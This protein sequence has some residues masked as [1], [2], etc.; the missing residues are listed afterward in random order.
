MNRVLFFLLFF[1][2]QS[3]AVDELPPG[4]L[5]SE[6][7]QFKQA[8][9]QAPDGNDGPLA[10]APIEYLRPSVTLDDE[11]SELERVVSETL[12]PP[13]LEEQMQEGISQRKLEQYGYDIFSGL[14]STFAPVAAIPVPEDYI[15]GPGDT[16]VVQVFG[17]VDV[18]YNLVVTREGRVLV[19]ELGDIQVAGLRFDEAK[20]LIVESLERVRIGAK[21]IATLSDL[22]TVQVLLVGEVSQP[23]AYTVSGLSSLLNTLVS[24]G[25]IRRTGSLRNIQ[26]KRSGVL[27]ASFDLY[28][29]LLNGDESNNIH[30]RHGDVVFVPPIGATIGV[31]GEVQRAAIY[32]LNGE[33]TVGD[34]LKLAG[35]LLP[36]AAATK[37]QIERI[38]NDDFYTLIEADLKGD[39]IHTTLK[40]GDLI[41]VLPVIEK[42]SNV[43][44]LDG[45][46]IAP[47]SYQ[48]RDGLKIGS[49]IASR[50]ML[51]QGTDFGITV[52]EREN[53]QT[54]R[55][56]VIYVDLAAA[57]AGD[58][59]AN[60][61]LQP[62]DRI[63]V[64]STHGNRSGQLR[65]TVEKLEREATVDQ[66]APV[67]YLNGFF[68]HPG[69]YPLQ[70]GLRVTDIAR[71]AGGIKPGTD[72]NYAVLS[73]SANGDNKT[74]ITVINLRRSIRDPRGDHNPILRPSDRLYFFDAYQDRPDLLRPEIEKLQKQAAKNE[75]NK[76]I[77]ISGEIAHPG[78][79]PL[80]AGMRLSDLIVAG[81]GLTE[82]ASSKNAI[83]ARRQQQADE[84]TR[85]VQLEVDLSDD[86]SALLA[87]STVLRPGDE[88]IIKSKPEWV[89]TTNKVTIKGE[90]LHPGTYSVDKRETLCSLVQRAGGFT[91]NAYLFG[92]VFTRE[93]VRQREQQALDRVMGELDDLLAEVHLSP[94]YDK[95]R[96]L[97][98]DR[99]TLDTYKVIKDLAPKKAVGR[100]VID[101]EGAVKS[102]R[103]AD[104]IV[105]ENGDTIS[106]PKYQDEVSVVGQVYFPTSHKF[107]SERAALDYINLSGGT[108]ELAQREHAYVVQANGEVM[109]VRSQA[110]TWGWLMSPSN[111]RVT[112]GST[113][114]VPLSVDRINGREFAQSWVDL[115]YKLTLGVASV[116]YLF[117]D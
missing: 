115:F 71:F 92:T 74:D 88:L 5:N 107:K 70:A 19:P 45:H 22:R 39:G 99:N 62:R 86:N 31:A 26:V 77:S 37:T 51:R 85:V 81:G 8:R 57:L 25:G 6:F 20:E 109:T 38:E 41:R 2:T 36:T 15:I 108:K 58:P 84:F 16:F 53:L 46:V 7:L 29:L 72:L 113:V 75:V 110:S 101:M 79:Y 63:V 105:L 76:T 95:D 47:G 64:F 49:I 91:E 56:E 48:W 114:F 55:S 106:I 11:P 93:S 89:D 14:A 103:E 44:Y 52:I 94:G 96:K 13:S 27:V 54:K 68:K 111:V 42:F 34:V 40:N 43:V 66:P 69:K 90:V 78:L 102:C 28:D 98:D 17:A 112:P 3:W 116:D 32:E 60:I 59:Q 97:P 24:A 10:I 18:Q 104:D 83:L 35:G 50:D 1:A 80:A 4:T 61:S 33:T 67:V 9:Q 23:G 30:L 21:A 87:A 65:Q 73:R 117:R 82:G 12:K 100:L